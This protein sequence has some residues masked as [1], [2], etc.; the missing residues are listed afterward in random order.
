[1]DKKTKQWLRGENEKIP[2]NFIGWK[3][4][5]RCFVWFY[6]ILGWIPVYIFIRRAYLIESLIMLLMM[7]LFS[8]FIMGCVIKYV[9][10]K[11]FV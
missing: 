2:H 11:G 4:F 3:I 5:A 10:K 7:I 1:M 8:I 6:L 9:Q